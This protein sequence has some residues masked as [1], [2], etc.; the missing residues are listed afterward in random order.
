MSWSS[1]GKLAMCLAPNVD[2]TEP[3]PQPQINQGCDWSGLSPTI[4]RPCTRRAPG[5]ATWD[6]VVSPVI[7]IAY[8]GTPSGRQPQATI[9]IGE[10]GLCMH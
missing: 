8:G 10:R 6:G 2:G 4:A 1:E 9:A 5:W 7:Y 3:P